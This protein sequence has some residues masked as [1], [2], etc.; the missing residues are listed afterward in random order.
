MQLAQLNHTQYHGPKYHGLIL[1]PEANKWPPMPP[2]TLNIMVSGLCH[3]ACIMAQ[4]RKMA[5]S[6]AP[7]PPHHGC[8]MAPNS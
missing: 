1:E 3:Y 6:D 4:S 8:I 5:S 2:L 7:G